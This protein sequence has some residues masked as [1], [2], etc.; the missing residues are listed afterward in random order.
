MLLNSLAVNVSFKK[1]IMKNKI[2]LSNQVIMITGV[3]GQ[4]GQSLI[5]EALNCGAKILCIDLSLEEMNKVKTNNWNMQNILL[6][7]ADI[8]KK[9]KLKKHFLMV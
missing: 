4:L 5:N 6:Q 3:S 8:R 7:Q 9:E 2:D 1:K